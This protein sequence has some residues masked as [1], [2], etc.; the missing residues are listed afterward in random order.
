MAAAGSDAG[1]GSPPGADRSVTPAS[2]TRP[3]PRRITRCAFTSALKPNRSSSRTQPAAPRAAPRGAPAPAPGAGGPPPPPPG[4]NPAG[5]EPCPRV[6]HV[7]DQ[8][9]HDQ[10]RRQPHGGEAG[11][12]ERAFR[13]E[14][15]RLLGPPRPEG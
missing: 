5:T 7:A 2:S 12:L 1:P 8:D 15:L 9:E 3:A 4:P 14:A 10:Q 6:E 13:G 11:P